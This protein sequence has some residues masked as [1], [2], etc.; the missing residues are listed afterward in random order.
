MRV[1][2][3][4]MAAALITAGILPTTSQASPQALRDTLNTLNQ[5]DVTH[6]EELEINRRG[7]IEIEGFDSNGAERKLSFDRQGSV[8]RDHRGDADEDREESID[9]ATAQRVV[10]WLEQQGHRDID[11][12]SADDGLIEIE[13]RDE[14][15]REVEMALDPA[16][17][18][19]VEMESNGDLREVL[20]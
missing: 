19:V 3:N 16:T 10:N 2:N 17:L 14:N 9:I 8:L 20:R 18:E 15:G 11:Q 4:V 6:I 12:I 5:Y 13:M 1:S 7:H